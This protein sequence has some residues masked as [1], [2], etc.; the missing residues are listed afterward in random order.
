MTEAIQSKAIA[1]KVAKVMTA[2]RK[3]P[4]DGNNT[5]DNYKYITGDKVFELLGG[6]MA[7][8]GLVALPSIIEL[9]TD[10]VPTKSG[11]QY[12]T[13][14]HG[15]ITLADADTG[16]TWTS[17]WYGEGADRGDKSINKA[18]TAMMKYYLLRL[19]QIGSGVDADADSPEIEEHQPQPPKAKAVAPQPQHRQQRPPADAPPPPTEDEVDFGMGGSEWDNLPN[20]EASDNAYADRAAAIMHSD[21]EISDLAVKLIKKCTELDRTSGD[22]TLSIVKKDGTGSG[23][24]G[25]L[26]GKIDNLTTKGAHRFILSALCGRSISQAEPPGWK[27]KELIDWLMDDKFKVNT[28]QA[29]KDVWSAVQ[30]VEK[31]TA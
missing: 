13:V 1:G 2:I 7:E 14:I 6:A 24:Y 3:L 30:Q 16:D 29:I 10:S 20:R 31:V 25:L 19:F 15:Q 21:A 5:Y 23:Q 26:V 12:R 4:K 9:N 18:M 8:A 17:D 28:E 22:K 27:V 11:S